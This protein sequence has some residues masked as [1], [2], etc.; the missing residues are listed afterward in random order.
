MGEHSRRGRQRPVNNHAV[1][2][3]DAYADADVDAYADAD[4]DASAA[5]APARAEPS[6]RLAEP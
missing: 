3:A 5:R 2:D 6:G 1:A 4:A